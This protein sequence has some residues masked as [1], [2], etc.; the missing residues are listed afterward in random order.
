MDFKD[1]YEILGVPPNAIRRSF[2][3]LS[4]TARKVHP[5]V[6]PGNKD[7]EEQFKAIN[8]AYQVLSGRQQRKKYDDCG[9]NTSNGSG[10]AVVNRIFDWQNWSAQPNQGA[11]V[12]YASPEDLEDLF[13]NDSPYSDFF[14]NIFGQARKGGRCTSARAVGGIRV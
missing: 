7:A 13:G 6:N 4:S 12:Q 1:Y 2:T 14:T 3:N 8:E 11:H 10:P 9:P 5:D